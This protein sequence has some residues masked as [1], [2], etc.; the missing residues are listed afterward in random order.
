MFRKLL[1]H[2]KWNKIQLKDHRREALLVRS[3]VWKATCAVLLYSLE[4]PYSNIFFS[5]SLHQHYSILLKGAEWH[6]LPTKAHQFAQIEKKS[7]GCTRASNMSTFLQEKTAFSCDNSF[8]FSKFRTVFIRYKQL[9][10]SF[11]SWLV[12]GKKSSNHWR[13]WF[14]PPK[15][16]CHVR[17]HFEALESWTIVAPFA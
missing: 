3:S 2:K 9:S 5:P 12:V 14:L 6:N 17:T 10:Y 4:C 8:F 16:F 13:W 15:V 1:G 11:W 7:A